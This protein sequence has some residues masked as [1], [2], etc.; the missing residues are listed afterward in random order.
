M[1]KYEKPVVEWRY[2]NSPLRSRTFVGSS[3]TVFINTSN[4]GF[5]A[6]APQAT[7]TN[8]GGDDPVSAYHANTQKVNDAGI[9][10]EGSISKQQFHT[11]ASFDTE[12]QEHVIVLRM[13][14]QTK[15]NVQVKR[16]VTVGVRPVCTSCGRRNK[17]TAKFCST[18]GTS[19]QI[20]A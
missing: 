16:A 12:S 15:D 7:Y 3:D 13:L 8:S 20:V 5:S 10:V 17:A 6:D 4:A 18:C 2:F 9:T 19:L 14:G 1:F 11:V